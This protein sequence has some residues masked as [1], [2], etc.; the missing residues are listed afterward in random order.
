MK[1]RLPGEVTPPRRSRYFTV[2]SAN[3]EF[4]Q[5]RSLE[6][7]AAAERTKFVEDLKAREQIDARQF[8]DGMSP[9]SRELIFK[10]MSKIAYTKNCNGRC[11]FCSVCAEPGITK[12][13]SYD[14]TEPI[15]TEFQQTH[16]ADYA[17]RHSLDPFLAG[18]LLDWG[19]VDENGNITRDFRDVLRIMERGLIMGPYDDPK[20]EP[21]AFTKFM[22]H[23]PP[24]SAEV[25]LEFLSTT[26]TAQEYTQDFIKPYI[27]LRISQTESNSELVELIKEKLM[28]RM[29]GTYGIRNNTQEYQRLI[30][31]NIGGGG[32]AFSGSLYHVGRNYPGDHVP[33]EDLDIGPLHSE[34]VMLT[35]DGLVSHIWVLPTNENPRGILEIPFSEETGVIARYDPRMKHLADSQSGRVNAQTDIYQALMP[36]L[37][38][39]LIATHDHAATKDYLTPRNE[40]LREAFAWNSFENTIRTHK[41]QGEVAKR[42]SLPDRYRLIT[43]RLMQTEDILNRYMEQNPDGGDDRVVGYLRHARERVDDLL[44]LRGS[45]G[46]GFMDIY[47]QLAQFS[48]MFGDP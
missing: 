6:E 31:A 24:H 41:E 12:Q 39:T 35:P 28:R 13:L 29:V 17:R 11:K 3:G 18:D 20:A 30:S 38:S 4:C 26:K 33:I 40:L 8:F 45:F 5:Y 43:D 2:Q 23:V 22:T 48:N 9:K 10:N 34:G 1:V 15:I 14:S 42:F 32:P 44:G 47:N 25:L 16:A 46:G 21:L 37:K 19:E 7:C 36:T 27:S